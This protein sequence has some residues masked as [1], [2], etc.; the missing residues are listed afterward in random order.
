MEDKQKL[1]AVIMGA[2]SAYIQME[3]PPPMATPEKIPRAK[4][5]S[6]I[7][8]WKILGRRKLALADRKIRHRFLH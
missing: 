8:R 3:P 7:N 2:I 1:T 6:T 4:P 5:R